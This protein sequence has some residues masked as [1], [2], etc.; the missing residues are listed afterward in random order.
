MPHSGLSRGR[1]RTPASLL[2]EQHL[3]FLF[4]SLQRFGCLARGEVLVTPDWCPGGAK[5]GRGLRR[6]V[7]LGLEPSGI[8]GHPSGADLAQLGPH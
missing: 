4:R 8:F 3:S 5:D 7:A 2:P 1:L 6:P